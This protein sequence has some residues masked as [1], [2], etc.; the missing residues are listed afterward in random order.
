MGISD[1]TSV[2]KEGNFTDFANKMKIL[3]DGRYEVGLP[4]K[5][6]TTNLDDNETLTWKRHERVI[7]KLKCGKFLD[8]YENVFREWEKMNIIERV[9]ENEVNNE[10]Y[11]LPHRPVIKLNSETTKIRPVFDASASEKGKLSLN[12]CLWKGINLIELIPDIL[13]RFRIY[14]IGI[15][16]D[17]EKAFLMLSVDPK[18]RDFLRFFY[19]SNERKMIYRH[20]R[21]VFGVS[22]SPYLLN[23]SVMHLL[24]NYASPNDE[25]AQKL[26][27]SFYVDNC[28]TGVYNVE[29]AEHFIEQSKLIMSKGCFNLRS[30]ESNKECRNVDKHSGETSV[31]GVIWNLDNDSLKCYTDLE[32]LTCETKIT[33]R[34]ILSVVQKIFDPIGMLSPT[35]LLPKLLLQEIWQM[36]IGWDHELPPDVIK[37]FLKWFYD[38]HLLKNVSI[39][40]HMIV[41]CSSELHVFVDACKGAYAA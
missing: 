16:A 14:P 25:V 13:D 23:A 35:L 22:S 18:D 17:I 28:V 33:K 3:P 19:P 40:R 38:V 27:Y 10:C 41:N 5:C 15:S 11:Y 7:H 12:E 31:L 8:D 2:A 32:V 6:S 37:R 4:W 20:C 1:P 26:K 34:L 24:E 39:S 29:E 21:V 9:P 36:K 30:F